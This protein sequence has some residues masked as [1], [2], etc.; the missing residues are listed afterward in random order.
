LF[1]NF[2]F[3]KNVIKSTIK[4]IE[5]LILIINAGGREYK[6]FLITTK[7]LPQIIAAVN[8]NNL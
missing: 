3:L 6:V 4:A 7:E 1:I 8:N 5:N 2:N